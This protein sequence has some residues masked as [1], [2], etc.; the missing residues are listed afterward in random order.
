MFG[1]VEGGEA[2]V[3][4]E[5]PAMLSARPKAWASQMA[6]ERVAEKMQEGRQHLQFA[7]V[8]IEAQWRHGQFFLHESVHFVI[9]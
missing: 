5:E 3:G 2:I 1:E 9:K 8:V 6:A 7:M 4:G